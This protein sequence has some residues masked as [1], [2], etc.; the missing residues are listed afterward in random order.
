MRFVNTLSPKSRPKI[1]IDL[2]DMVKTGAD[3]FGD[4]TLYLYDRAGEERRFTYNDLLFHVNAIGTA[5]SKYNL[6][7]KHIAIV[8]DTCPEYIAS[9]LAVVNGN[10]V[11]VPLPKE[12][13]ADN[14][15]DFMKLS[16]CDAVI[17]TKAMNTVFKK[18]KQLF[19][20]IK[21]FIPIEPEGDEG[22][23]TVPYS[24]LLDEG[25][26]MLEEGCTVL[27][28]HHIDPEAMCAIIFTSGTTGTSKGVMLNQRNLTT[29]A[30]SAGQS[31]QYDED[32]TFI[33]FLPPYH[34]YEMS[35]GQFAIMNLGATIKINSSL[36]HTIRDMASF[37]PNALMLVPLFVETMHKKIWDEIDKR[38]MRKKVNAAIKASNALLAVGIDMRKKF[39]GKITSAFGGNLKS[40]VCG[41]A[42]VNPEI[43]KDFHAFG[44]LILEGYGI[45]ECS[46]LVSVNRPDGVRL[47]T[48]GTPVDGCTVRIDVG[49][50]GKT[51]EILVKGDNVML[52]YYKNPEATAEVFTV[53]GYFRTGDIGYMDEDGYIYI[54][55]R[56]KNVII[57]SNGKNVFPEE[58][59]EYI[60]KIPEVLESVVIGRKDAAGVPRITAICVPDMTKY[61]GADN[62]TVE[63]DIRAK[64]AEMNK[65]LPTFKQVAVTEIRWEEF[66]KTPS[67]KIKRYKVQ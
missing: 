28:E 9:Y 56:K 27:T 23:D 45:T 67:R 12:L 59:E 25:K 26:Q 51:G 14:L 65:K 61:E 3:N 6:F 8:G 64:I 10:G 22:D 18:D 41:G 20:N 48:V 38:G 11:I 35:I 16:E 19:D 1:N 55:G 40:I 43:I 2:Y 34:T 50:D 31:M 24:L 15:A 62:E 60:Y 13:S 33:S 44:I 29:A 7:G 4:K 42:A 47:R 63:A 5:L 54:T 36:K 17:Y 53:D 52:G 30:N 66:E 58:I 57:L 39:F 21:C 46:P 49:D 32:N 37:K